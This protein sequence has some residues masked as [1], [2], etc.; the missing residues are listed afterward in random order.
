MLLSKPNCVPAIKQMGTEL[1]YSIRYRNGPRL[2]ETRTQ[3][4]H[5]FHFPDFVIYKKC[6]KA[7]LSL[8]SN[9]SA[10]Y[11]IMLYIILFYMKKCYMTNSV[12]LL[13][14]YEVLDMTI[15]PTRQNRIAAITNIFSFRKSNNRSGFLYWNVITN[16]PN[17][18]RTM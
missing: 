8:I 17:P 18:I 15:S 12:F 2:C 16:D 6:T 11:S 13:A 7:V 10:K 9:C 4:K 1:L 5:F 14:A 3:I